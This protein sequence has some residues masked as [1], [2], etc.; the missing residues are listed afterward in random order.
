M[1]KSL[2]VDTGTNFC[3]VYNCY[4]NHAYGYKQSGILTGL[5][6]ISLFWLWMGIYLG[7]ILSRCEA[8]LVQDLSLVMRLRGNPRST[9]FNELIGYSSFKF[10]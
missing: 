2:R 6:G 7:E 1:M 9:S 4:D 10:T 3:R 8:T 5:V